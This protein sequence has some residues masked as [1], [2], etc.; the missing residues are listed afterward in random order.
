MFMFWQRE[1]LARRKARV[2][3]EQQ[4]GLPPQEPLPRGRSSKNKTA[5]QQNDSGKRID[6][7]QKETVSRASLGS[8]E[9]GGIAE[10]TGEGEAA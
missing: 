1:Q 5:Q 9:G 4:L 2:E 3:E 10:E 7:Q 8:G 6:A